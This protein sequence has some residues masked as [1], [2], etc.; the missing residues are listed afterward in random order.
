QLGMIFH[1]RRVG[2]RH[3]R[4]SLALNAIGCVLTALAT[5]VVVVS[6]FVEG[7]WISV[8][9]IPATM[10]L[11]RAIRRA[12]E[13]F[14]RAIADLAP[15]R[16]HREAPPIVLVPLHRLDRPTRQALDFAFAVSPDIQ[17]LQLLTEAED[18]EHD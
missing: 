8:L 6:K 5:A 14:E 9:A 10:A 18:E 11:F 12:S 16:I 15:V 7:A 4:R 13:R 17:A 2:G 3:A 1:W